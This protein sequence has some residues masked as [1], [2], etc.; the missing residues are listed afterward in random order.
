MKYTYNDNN[1]TILTDKEFKT[2]KKDLVEKHLTQENLK[3]IP[4]L[5][6][7]LVDEYYKHFFDK[8]EHSIEFLFHEFRNKY[9]FY[10]ILEKD[11]CE[12]LYYDL[13]DIIFNKLNMDLD[14]EIILNDEN[15]IDL[16]FEEFQL[17]NEL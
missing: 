15:Y 1:A 5:Y 12:L 10:G 9:K 7:L 13:L 14:L 11:D 6:N 8:M 4:S 2:I 17:K 3:S 16:V